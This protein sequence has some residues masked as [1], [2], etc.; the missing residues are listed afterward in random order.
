MRAAIIARGLSLERVQ[1][2]LRVRGHQVS[3]ATLSY[4]Q[5]GRS[6]PDR[7]SSLSAVNSLEDILQLPR[8]ELASK[9]PARRGVRSLLHKPLDDAQEMMPL[10]ER[11]EQMRTELGFTWD[12]GF[13][14]LSIHSVVDVG[15]D[16]QPVRLRFRHV[17]RARDHLIDRLPVHCGL[18]DRDAT[19]TVHPIHNCSLGRVLRDPSWGITVAELLLP[20]P[21][22][23]GDTLIIE[24]GFSIDGFRQP[25]LFWQIDLESPMREFYQEINFSPDAIPSR[26][27]AYRVVEGVETI[28]S[29]VPHGGRISHLDLDFGPGETGLRWFWPDLPDRRQCPELYRVRDVDP[30]QS[31]AD[32]R[33]PGVPTSTGEDPGRPSRSLPTT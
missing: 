2:H 17:V 25:F 31:G 23:R 14:H 13:E 12:D 6:H 32:K 18:I 24:Y 20:V 30:D 22:R 15:P 4:W 33:E 16:R 26:A 5:S 9:L 8:G 1:Y 27:E 21:V 19:I 3:V 10:G 29:L 28:R 11:V 7:A